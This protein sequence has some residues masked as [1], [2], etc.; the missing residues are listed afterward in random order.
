MW[1]APLTSKND[2]RNSVSSLNG[3]ETY[4][5]LFREGF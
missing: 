3:I 5:K 4:L 1:Q 2:V